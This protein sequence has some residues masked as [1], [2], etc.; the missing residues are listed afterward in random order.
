MPPKKQPKLDN[1][2]VADKP[3]KQRV[4][5]NK[6]SK[7]STRKTAKTKPKGGVKSSVILEAA[8]GAGI[9]S[10]AE[11]Q[12]YM[13]E[14]WSRSKSCEEKPD[15]DVVYP[16]TSS[17]HVSDGELSSS[18]SK[19]DER[20]S[21]SSSDSDSDS[22]SSTNELM[23]SDNPVRRKI[24]FNRET[25][26]F[27]PVQVSPGSLEN[28]KDVRDLGKLQ[29]ML[30]SN[31]QAVTAITSMLDVIKAM[32]NDHQDERQAQAS[33]TVPGRVLPAPPPQNP[34]D[35]RPGMSETTIYTHAVPSASPSQEA[36]RDLDLC[37]D[38]LAVSGAADQQPNV[39]CST[40]PLSTLALPLINTD[41][42][43][44]ADPAAPA[45]PDVMEDEVQ[46]ERQAAKARTDQMILEAERQKIFMERPVTGKKF[47][48]TNELL[49]ILDKPRSHDLT[50]D[51]NLYGLSVHL[52]ANTI[53][54]I[55][56]GQFVNLSI[57][58]PSDKVVPDD[59]P[60]RL[61]LVHQDG[62][63]GVAP[64]TDK[65][66]S[67]VNSFK[68]WELAF[69]VYAGVFTRAHPQRGP[70]LLEYK[71]IIRRASETYIWS[72]VYSYDKIH[73]THM[74]HNPGRT[75]S[76]KHRDAWSDHVKIYK[77]SAL[78]TGQDATNPGRKRKPC[79]F[80]NKNGK[81]NK[82]ANCEYDH[83]CVHCRL[84]GHGKHNCRKLQAA[85]R[86]EPAPN[87]PRASVS[88][89]SSNATA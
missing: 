18:G 37:L 46:R 71:H 67:I 51:N 34:R 50:C 53:M 78:S 8:S 65:D 84:F 48:P 79:R 45:Q 83:K 64:Y 81:C 26:Q 29:E 61:Q 25:G 7:A 35:T 31:P 80:F 86:E 58:I 77:N 89:S 9:S 59:E 20:D 38:R 87:V 40:N 13:R 1:R 74:Q 2:G 15:Q 5:V 12:N 16:T 27:T 56:S 54:L 49:Q 23:D 82:G 10:T 6:K 43:I 57:L 63:L 32:Q 19:S 72:N 4:G 44:V 24:P 88:T 47:V 41:L 76:K 17:D 66:A 69:D 30:M 70:E 62:R 36:R 21:S 28:G 33:S 85:K 14:T 55:E 39:E 68:R 75:W 52:D 11:L 3:P 22:D 60:E 73:R 42:P